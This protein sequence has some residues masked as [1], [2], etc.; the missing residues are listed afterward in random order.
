MKPPALHLHA[1]ASVK[2]FML[3]GEVPVG[4]GRVDTAASIADGEVWES[5]CVFILAQLLL[6]DLATPLI[7]LH[8][9]ED[10]VVQNPFFVDLRP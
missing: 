4:V 10:L 2:D 5:L 6:Y 8:N 1:L 3:L 9:G 7:V